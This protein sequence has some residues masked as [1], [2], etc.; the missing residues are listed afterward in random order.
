MNRVAD[1]NRV[2]APCKRIPH[3]VSGYGNDCAKN[4]CV[5]EKY[6]LTGIELVKI[7]VLVCANNITAQHLKPFDVFGV[8]TAALDPDE[9]TQDQGYKKYK[10]EEMMDGLGAMGKSEN[11]LKDVQRAKHETKPRD[12][13]NNTTS[14]KAPVSYS[15]QCG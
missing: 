13:A 1:L 8:K 10:A 4:N 3:N 11:L 7:E 9:K 15:F 12:H 2:S 5:P 6:L 14:H